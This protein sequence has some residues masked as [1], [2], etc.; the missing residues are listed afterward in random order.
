MPNLS[1]FPRLGLLAA[2]AFCPA[3]CRKLDERME[4]TETR[5]V[6]EYSVMPKPMAKSAERFF[7]TQQNQPSVPQENPLK[8]DIPEGWTE[9][10]PSSSPG[11]MR[12]IDLRFG[13]NGEGECYLSALPNKGG[14]LEA[15]LNRW[16]GQMG[17]PP[18]TA[19]E[20][21]K[22][23]KKTFLN[24]ESAFV[25]FDGDFKGFGAAEPQKDFRLLGIVQEAPEFTL[26]VKLT[27]PKDL[28]EK[29]E[30]AFDQFCQ[31]VTIKR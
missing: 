22:L 26:F 1:N 25:K 12:L 11:G 17:Q 7:D 8:W 13:P 24:R 19:D 14:G 18:Y 20:L 4:I 3:S 16:R 2:I 27:G 15:N 5:P 31:S 30:A 10:A 23:P 9:A 21:A 29:N 28:V 6:S